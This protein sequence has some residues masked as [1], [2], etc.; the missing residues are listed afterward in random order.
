M[1]LKVGEAGEVRGGCAIGKI[2][3]PSSAEFIVSNYISGTIE[4]QDRGG[5]IGANLE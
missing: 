4:C 5:N 2:A 3:C 1:P